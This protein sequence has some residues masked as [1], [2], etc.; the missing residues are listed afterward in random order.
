LGGGEATWGTAKR[1]EKND[2]RDVGIGRG[3]GY[4]GGSVRSGA[5][6]PRNRFCRS[7]MGR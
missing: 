5:W 6:N 1:L 3:C 4:S 7:S 2:W